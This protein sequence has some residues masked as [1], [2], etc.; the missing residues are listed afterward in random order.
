MIKC[1]TCG[2]LHFIMVEEFDK[3]EEHFD[4]QGIATCLECNDRWWI[5]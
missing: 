5:I 3:A 1:P 2:E 4:A